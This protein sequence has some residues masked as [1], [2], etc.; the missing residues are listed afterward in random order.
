MPGK[1]HGQ[2]GL[3]GYSLW[4]HK[5]SDTTESLS[6]HTLDC[7]M[8]ITTEDRDNDG[9]VNRAIDQAYDCQLNV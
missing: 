9:Y 7:R 6:I 8:L 5:E 1:F 4:G 3:V 2:R